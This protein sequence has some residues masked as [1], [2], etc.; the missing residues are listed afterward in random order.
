VSAG[1]LVPALLG[2]AGAGAAVSPGPFPLRHVADVE[3]PGAANRFDYQD[4]DVARGRLVIAHMN[5]DSVVIVRASDGSVVKVL[6]GIRTPRGVAVAQDAGRIFVTSMPA[7]LVVIDAATLEEIGRVPTGRA[8][9]GVAWDPRDRVVAVSDQRDGAV[10]LLAD[11]GSGRRGQVEVGAETGNVAF[12]AGR[13]LFWVTVVNR[14]PPDQLV[15]IDPA[16]ARVAAR[17]ALPGCQGAHGLRL[18]PDGR[19][20]LV[21][22]E[23]NAVLARVGLGAPDVVTAKV[24]ADPD[25][26]AVDAG[27]GW[28]YVAAESGELTVFDLGRAGLVKIDSEQVGPAAHSVAVDAATHRVFFPLQAGPSGRP[29]LRIMQPAGS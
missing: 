25:V 20:A 16:S 5:D 2:I 12:D 28:L 6:G 7:T 24:G 22:C 11:A 10:S 8:P 14:S 4:L 23:A 27:K 18:S 13:G 3:L 21:A 26:L 19:S 15:A 1:R 29:V 9:D 17:I